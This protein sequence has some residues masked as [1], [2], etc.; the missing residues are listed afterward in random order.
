M[1]ESGNA[2]KSERKTKCS[3]ILASAILSIAAALMP[4]RIVAQEQLSGSQSPQSD[5]PLSSQ[6]S[7]PY[8]QDDSSATQ[9]DLL[10]TGADNS[11]L[12]GSTTSLNTT[13]SIQA[14]ALSAQAIISFLEQN[15]D[16]TVELKGLAADRIREQGGEADENSITD[17]QLYDQISANPSLRASITTFLRARGYEIADSDLSTTDAGRMDSLGTAASSNS[18]RAGTVLP[19]TETSRRA[20]AGGDQRASRGLI[21]SQMGSQSPKREGQTI[22][23][24]DL[25][26]ALRQPAPYNLRSMRDLYTQVPDQNLKLKRFGSEFFLPKSYSV[27]TATTGNA[28]AALDVPVDRD[29]IVGPGDTLSIELWGGATLGITRTIG[30]D[31]R[32]MLPEA[33]SLQVAGLSLGR[34]EAVIEQELKKQ[35][36]DAQVA[37]T[38]SRLRSIHVY[39]TGDV[40]RPGAYEISALAT[41]LNALYAAGGPTASGSLRL[42]RHM[43]G[44][45]LLEEVDLY[46]FFLHGVHATGVH[47]ESND[48]LLVPPAG[49]QVAI[50]GAVRRPAVYELKPG[51]TVLASALEDAGGVLPAASLN[52]VT[53]ERIVPGRDRET[54]ALSAGKEEASEALAARAKTFA[55]QDG[56][57]VRIDPVLPYSER[58]VYLDGHVSRP[59][60]IA[61]HDGMRLSDVLH[62]YRDLLPEPAPRAEIL[63]LTAP[64]MHAE[65]ISFDLPSLLIGNGDLPLQPFDTI[66]VHSRYE[67][68]APR[69]TISGEVL[70]PGN[71]PLSERMTVAQLVRMAGGFKRDAYTE[72]ADLTSYVVK[73]GAVSSSLHSLPIGS[74][75]RGTDPAEDIALRAGDM[76][77]IRQ[78]TN[79][80]N[81]GES[82]RIDGQVSYPGTYGF[83]EGEHLSSVLRRA[84]GMLS[85]AYPAG[86]VLIREQVR[87]VEEK[88]REDLIRQIQ[89]NSAAARLSPNLG[90]QDTGS[91]LQLIQAQQEQVIADLKN[92]PPAGRMVIHITSDIDSWANTAADIELRRGDVLTIPKQPGFIVVTGQ[93]YNATALTFTPDKTAAWYLSHAGGTNSTAERKEIFIIRANGSIIG[94]HSGHWPDGKV[95]DTHLNPGDVIVVPQKIIGSSLFWR[96]LLTTAQLAS[97]IAITAA[98]ASI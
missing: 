90:A 88:S 48:T 26:R 23:S 74:V 86:A 6:G 35:Y 63:R 42:V 22:A 47:F 71:Y 59:G 25:P 62:N 1:R 92:H 53:V 64:D 39:V 18:L 54:L 70:H 19:L 52:H 15:P 10:T 33:G 85:T 89:A 91:F 11:S 38:I 40:Q 17:Q 96:N 3:W 45:Q 29:Y 84:G 76:L 37:V 51:E 94:R 97:S 82:I 46:E 68:D 55:L 61:F 30:R 34:T 72:R 57:R 31:G 24:T 87:E 4:A 73:D 16:V 5:T 41:P 56:D 21:Q 93:V 7:D 36:R 2:A 77:S 9:H 32:I 44:D 75:L 28:L 98:V 80:E 60:R 12:T 69:V 67:A 83:S 81:V 95:L 78:L 27:A 8:S 13:S 79:W 14:P 58:V 66:R 49:L 50:S 43:R 65:A 20:N